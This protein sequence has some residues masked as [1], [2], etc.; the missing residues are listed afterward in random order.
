T[1]PILRSGARPGDHVYVTGMLG[2]AAAAV[3][4]WL[5]GAVPLPAARAAYVQP[6]PRIREAR[7]LAERVE[8]HALIDLSDGLS[9]DAAHLAAASSCRVII[10]TPRLPVHP[11]AARGPQPLRL[12][13]AGGDDYE[14]CFTAAPDEMI[15]VHD[16]F[17]TEFELPVTDVGEVSAGEGLTIIGEDGAPLSGVT[18]GWD[19]FGAEP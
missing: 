5:E 2:G 7:W 13:L 16:A 19:H 1:R 3:A 9:S 18:A 14:L 6:T 11:A 8:L 17:E 10:H 12:A 15:Q 4:A